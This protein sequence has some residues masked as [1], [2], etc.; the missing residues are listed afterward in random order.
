[1]K[2]ERIVPPSGQDI[3]F[4]TARINESAKA[5]GVREEAYSFA[6]FIRDDSC[7]I[8]AGCNGSVV[9][10]SIYTDQLWVDVSYRGR[11]LGKQLMKQVHDY[12]I[13]IGC[14]M[15]TVNTM[16]FQKARS[17]YEHLGYICDFERDGYTNGG[18]CIFLRKTLLPF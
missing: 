5:L 3:D 15:A 14:T 6:F 12:G 17:F 13:E 8:V 11:G 2:I 18:S 7:I 10:G 4:L 9:Y 1:M 16:S